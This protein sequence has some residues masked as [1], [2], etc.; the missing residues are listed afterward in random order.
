M[1]VQDI[2]DLVVIPVVD[3]L[4]F[5]KADPVPA[6]M[7]LVGIGLAESGFHEIRQQGGGPATSPWQIERETHDDTWVNYLA[8]RPTVADKVLRVAA[9]YPAPRGGNAEWLPW[10]WRYAAAMCRV[11][12]RRKPG[13]IPADVEGQAAYWKQHYNTPLGAGTVEHYLAAWREAGL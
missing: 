10:N 6:R 5:D 1:N 2:L 13:A 8:S 12:L 11:I 9:L 7:F 4:G 3:E